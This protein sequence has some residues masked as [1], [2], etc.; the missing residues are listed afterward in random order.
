MDVR[1]PRTGEVDYR[2]EPATPDEVAREAAAARAAQRAWLHVGLEG[3]IDAMLAFAKALDAHRDALTAQLTLDTGRYAESAL[4]V[5]SV[6]GAIEHWCD[7]TPELLATPAARPT[8]L[9]TVRSQLMRTPYA[10]VGVIS[11]WNFPLL[12]SFV[13]AI[14]GLLA[15]CAVL[16]KPSEVT[17]RFLEPLQAALNDVPA[18]AS[19]FRIVKGGG[20]VGAALVGN[21][22]T[23]CFTGS[24][25]T[26]RKVAAAAAEHFIAANLELGGKDPA[27]VFADADL[28]RAAAALS[29]GST[30]NAGQSC[31]SI[32]RIYV[33]DRARDRFVDALVAATEALTLNIDDVNAGQIGPV[34]SRPQADV[35]QAHLDDAVAKGARILCGGQLIERGGL[36][37][38][39]T[40]LTDVSHDMLVMRE[41]SFGPLLP[42]MTFADEDEAIRLANDT[43]FGLS[44]A[45][46]TQDRERLYRVAARLEAG[47]VSAN[48][49]GLTSFIHEGAKQAFKDSG[50]GGSRM[51]DDAVARFF[52][53]GV[54]LDNVD[55]SWNPWWFQQ[56]TGGQV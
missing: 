4:E 2:F 31:L 53:K 55:V 17:P 48:D 46:F 54:V 49:A 43:T 15:G 56:N 29:W 40:V 21:V 42:V 52:R 11:P 24:V 6:I 10:L 5:Q 27:L 39:P 37:C 41:E 3:R 12:L 47:A 36:W 16:L 13:D 23:V 20:D 51:G 44:A 35:L 7:R 32:E 34:I 50:L 30:V 45:V 38:Q 19:I 22:D 14:P 25:A 9:P 28:A 33:E 18:L 8:R 26:G 1:N